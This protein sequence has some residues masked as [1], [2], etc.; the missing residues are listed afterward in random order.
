MEAGLIVG[1]IRQSHM[2]NKDT[3]ADS[4]LPLLILLLLRANP[5]HLYS[6]IQY[7]QRFRSP[8]RLSGEG[9]YYLNSLEAAVGWVESIEKG[10]LSCSEE[11]FDRNV[12]AA[13]AR[14]AE[15]HRLETEA[16]ELEQTA[17][18][19][20]SPKRS[21]TPQAL[22]DKASRL[23]VPNTDRERGEVLGPTRDLLVNQGSRVVGA[24]SKQVKGI[25]NFVFGEGE[26]P[27]DR[28][29][30]V[31]RPTGEQTREREE[32][33]SVRLE[34]AEIQRAGRAEREQRDQ[35]LEMLCQM[36]PGI[37]PTEYMCSQ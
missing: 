33:A 13:V 8:E 29:R 17:I 26:S 28:A 27:P 19:S 11:D 4:F 31:S 21:S 30:D 5:P 18:L 37:Y 24:V 23:M 22:L 6:N 12:E 7:I 32:E 9:G 16:Q 36:F 3:S 25:G 2:A 34:N 14:I 1:L 20:S 15:R 10:V 35:T